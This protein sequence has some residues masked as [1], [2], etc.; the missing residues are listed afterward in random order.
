M[1]SDDDI[2]I[3]HIFDAAN[4]AVSFVEGRCREDLF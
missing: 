1:F 3:R 4:E 2:R